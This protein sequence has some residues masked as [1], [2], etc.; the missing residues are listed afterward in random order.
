MAGRAMVLFKFDK[1]ADALWLGIFD[2]LNELGGDGD[3]KDAG[4]AIIASLPVTDYRRVARAL[5]DSELTGAP[6]FG[7]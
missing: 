7:F 4:T 6:V 1:A 3:K 5:N 2:A